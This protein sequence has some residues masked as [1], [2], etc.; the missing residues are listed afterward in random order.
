MCEADRIRFVKMQ[1]VGN[2]FVVIDGREGSPRDW[3]EIAPALCAERVGVGA[4]GL[5]VVAPSSERQARMIMYNPDGSED[6]C[7]NGL[8]CVARFVSQ[9]RDADLVIDTLAGSRQAAVRFD[10]DGSC[11]VTVDMGTPS[12]DPADVPARIPQ[13]IGYSLPVNGRDFVATTLSTGTAHTILFVD[14]L[15]D[16]DEFFAASP[17]IE[18][19]PFFPERTSLMW[20][21]VEGPNRLRLRIWERGAGETWGCGT[22]ACAAAVAA[23]RQGLAASPVTVASKGGELRIEW[24]EG[25]RIRMTGPAEYVYRGVTTAGSQRQAEPCR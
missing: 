20:T 24:S 18:N 21:R 3:Q 15:P 11:L 22:G 16:D 6:F 19:H 7:G 12:F 17:R 23:I 5:L 25:G 14:E 2:H 4:D 10:L 13:S 1:G 9:E 8:R